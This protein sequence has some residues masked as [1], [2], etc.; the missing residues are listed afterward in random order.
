M[1]GGERRSVERRACMCGRSRRIKRDK[2]EVSSLSLSRWT[3]QGKEGRVRRTFPSASDNGGSK[4]NLESITIMSACSHEL[5]L[6]L[7]TKLTMF[8]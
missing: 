2:K 4:D 6:H 3:W 5:A 1:V 8:L 7:S